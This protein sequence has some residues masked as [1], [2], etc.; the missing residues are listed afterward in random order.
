[1]TQ[2]DKAAKSHSPKIE[3]LLLSWV[4]FAR[5]CR[6][7]V[8]LVWF[9]LA[10][11][12]L[13]LSISLL[14]INTDT[15]DM[16]D[17]SAPYRVAQSEFEAAFPDLND[18]ILIIIQTDNQDELDIFSAA[19]AEELRQSD[20]VRSVSHPAS[21]P[22]FQK[23]GL[24][25]LETEELEMQLTQLS[26][27]APLIERLNLSPK[28]DTL[29]DTLSQGDGASADALFQGISQTLDAN[30]SG[31]NKPLSWREAFAGATQAPNQSVI[32]L[33][34]VLDFSRVRPAV[35][36]QNLIDKLA[37]DISIATSVKAGVHVTG[38]PV[39]RSD[40][41]KSVS[42]GIGLAL[43]ISFV[44]VGIILFIALRSASLVFSVLVSLVI[45]ILITAGLAALIYGELNLVSVAFTVLMVGLGVDFSI[46]LL[47]HL[48]HKRNLGLSY[49]AAFYRTS[50]QIGTALVLTAPSTALAF[51][52]FAPT[53]FVGISQLGVIAAMGVMIAFLVAT[54][55]LP[56]IF[57]YLPSK[58]SPGKRVSLKMNYKPSPAS[59]LG[60]S[61][62]SPFAVG[63]IVLG[64][65]ALALMPKA[66]FDADPMALRDQQAPSVRAF[67]LLFADA[68][69]VPYRLNILIEDSE[70]VP[71]IINDL[72]NLETVRSTR[73]IKNFIPVDQYDK[74]DLIDYAAIGLEFALSAEGS[75]PSTEPHALD[76]LLEALQGN[77]SAAAGNFAVVLNQWKSAMDSDPDLRERSERD[78]FLYW[79]REIERLRAQIQPSEVSL[80]TLPQNLASR[81]QTQDGLTRV[82]II[83]AEDV[84]RLEN[85]RAFVKSI[86]EPFPQ[87][88]G[89]A[90]S[91]QEAGDIIQ[92]S[93]LQAIGIALMAVS[94]LLFFVVR[95][96]KLVVIML[97]PLLLAG[98]LTTAT[99]VIFGLPY[100]FAN[101][102]VLPLLIGIGV[103]SSLHLA[104]QARDA[105]R[106]HSVIDNIT[107]RAVVFSAVTT[108]ASFGSLAF[109]AHR[110]T[111]SMGLLLMIAIGWVLICTLSVTPTLLDWASRKREEV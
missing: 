89:S 108:I 105:P 24:L 95:N 92:N 30:I 35:P 79:P 74:L 38:N 61:G 66:R 41:L 99:G 49:P 45:S 51:L 5:R 109:S 46:H 102:I 14:G 26:E 27:A 64:L 9:G 50:R 77:P 86:T 106:A 53:K 71:T 69:T 19:M 56:A 57:S 3:A 111:A 2:L 18:Q 81:Y 23:N 43:F 75:P 11:L 70:T 47:M 80:E 52:A 40:E 22:F 65:C 4:T 101:V 83:P 29:F 28:L 39:L 100:N 10:A 54:S 85:R 94:I 97:A 36:V 93:M 76:R 55:L 84:R 8:I 44:M 91:V 82:E 20:I 87:A 31:L 33:D 7:L 67:N 32:L 110:G 96:I 88:T 103:D 21:D 1:M 42:Q 72:E 25:Y 34:P 13:W 37:S 98:I 15:S 60:A 107:P 104:L 62:R 17:A 58:A 63:V 48:Q 73:S 68:D 16:I 59:G 6:N 90:R 12:G 78:V